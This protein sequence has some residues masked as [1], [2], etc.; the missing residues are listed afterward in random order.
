MAAKVQKTKKELDIEKIVE[1]ALNKVLNTA[2]QFGVQ[3]GKCEAKEAFRKTEMRLYAYPEL[4]ENIKKYKQ[5]IE[6]LRQ[7]SPGRSKDLVFFSAHGGG[8]RLSDEEIQEARIFVIQKKIERDQE[9]IDEIDF[10]LEA[11]KGDEYYPIIDMKY[12]KDMD[13][14]E[15]APEF[16]C[17]PRTVRRHKS[18]LV[19]RIAVKLYGAGAVG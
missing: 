14:D 11:V 17:D 18:R 5:D 6:D 3:K 4:V 9:E 12:F 8:S 10:A 1:Q 13:D 7:E 16:P 15:I 2:L 19:R